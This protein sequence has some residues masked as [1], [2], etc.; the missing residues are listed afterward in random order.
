MHQR[1][2]DRS[3]FGVPAGQLNRKGREDET[4]VTPIRE[5]PGAEEGRPKFSVRENPLRGGLGDRGLPC[6]RQPVQPVDG[7]LVEVPRPA[8]NPV[9]NGTT[10]PL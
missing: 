10:R 4:E 1:N 9:Q 7:G 8:F 6:P 2:E 5:V 3:K